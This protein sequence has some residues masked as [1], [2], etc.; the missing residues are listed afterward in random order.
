MR[1]LKVLFVLIIALSISACAHVGEPVAR[2]LKHKTR[3]IIHT[4]EGVDFNKVPLKNEDGSINA[5]IEIPS[6]SNQKWEVRKD[7]T[8][9]W[10]IKKGDVRFVN[11]LPYPGNYGMIP[12][13]AVGDGDPL[14]VLILGS[15]KPR[16]SV[17]K[18]RIIGV[19]RAL[20]K[21]E[22]DDKLIAVFHLSEI[23]EAERK[24]TKLHTVNSLSEL[25]MEFPGVRDI[26]RTWFTYYKR[27]K[28]GKSKMK[29]MGFDEIS[30]AQDI[31]QALQ[32][33]SNIN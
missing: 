23:S 24:I 26:V 12:Q 25:E 19:L 29:V 13:T 4:L 31:V 9:Y 7:G 2:G 30:D 8:L 18:I 15:A 21:G 17:V 32:I 3:G 27:K 22:Q 10:D 16:G 11:Y 20:D 1:S 6:G 28:S 5:V 33:S 14:D